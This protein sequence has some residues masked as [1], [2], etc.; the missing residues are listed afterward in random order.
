MMKLDIPYGKDRQIL[1]IDESHLLAVVH[2]NKVKRG[3]ESKIL[4][5][6]L[7]NPVDSP[8]FADFIAR[9]RK[10]VFIVNDGTRPTPTATVLDI[11]KND[12]STLNANFIISTGVHRA[13]T[14]EEFDFIFGRHYKYL[15]DKVFV[16]DSKKDDD[17]VFVGKSSNGTEM[18]INKLAM[19]SDKI[20]IIGSVE[21]HYFAG[22]TGG[23][24]SFLPGVASYKQ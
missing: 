17:M 12:I 10:P 14:E 21:P 22:Y 16:H 1:E 7:E 4:Q 15:K 19:E 8:P 2:P 23:R 9:A 18:H 20:I 13:P 5:K 24:K 11:L 6:A 3:D